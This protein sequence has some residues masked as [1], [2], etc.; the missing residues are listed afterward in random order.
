MNWASSAIAMRTTRTPSPKMPP[1]SRSTRSMVRLAM[2]GC[3][4]GNPASDSPVVLPSKMPPLI[5]DLPPALCPGLYVH[6]SLT[7]A[8]AG[9]QESVADIGNYVQNYE[10]QHEEQHRALHNQVV[11]G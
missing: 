7:V 6:V 10:D 1:G 11:P 2:P 5:D 8:D 9:I 3:S 4:S